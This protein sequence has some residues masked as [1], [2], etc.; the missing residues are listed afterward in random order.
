MRITVDIDEPL[1][2]DLLAITGDTKRSPAVARAVEDFVRRS[3]L[4]EFARLIRQGSFEDAF[5]PG[6]DP[7]Q[8]GL[9][10]A[11]DQAPYGTPPAPPASPPPI[12]D[13]SR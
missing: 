7:D 13:G 10:A 9:L 12:T 11:E 4:R 1:L 3:K 2:H 8:P 5:P 6:Y